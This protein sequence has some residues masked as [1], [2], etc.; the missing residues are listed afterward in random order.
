MEQAT[1]DSDALARM[2]FVS[3]NAYQVPLGR[4]GGRVTGYTVVPVGS[5]VAMASSTETTD[6]H[7]VSGYHSGRALFGDAVHLE[8]ALPRTR[9]AF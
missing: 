3:H 4:R 8:R 1:P 5:R 2:L 6:G 7:Q 9:C